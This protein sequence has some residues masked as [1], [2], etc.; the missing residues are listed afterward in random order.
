L[1]ITPLSIVEPGGSQLREDRSLSIVNRGYC[2][3]REKGKLVKWR[4]F[5][6]YSQNL[7]KGILPLK[8]NQTL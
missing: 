3:K 8:M 2:A 5:T 4:H 1:P 6:R 7:G